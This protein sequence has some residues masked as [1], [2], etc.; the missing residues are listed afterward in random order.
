MMKTRLWKAYLH[1]KKSIGIGAFPGGSRRLG[2]ALCHQ[3]RCVPA[4][5]REVQDLPGRGVVTWHGFPLV[6]LL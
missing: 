2:F 5:V 4:G 3:A 1:G 6:G